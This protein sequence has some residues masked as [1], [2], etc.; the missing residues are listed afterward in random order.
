MSPVLKNLGIRFDR[1]ARAELRD[2]FSKDRAPC[3]GGTLR[4]RWNNFRYGWWHHNGP[5][6]PKWDVDVFGYDPESGAPEDKEDEYEYLFSLYQ[7]GWKASHSVVK[8]LQHTDRPLT[9][10]RT[11]SWA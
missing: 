5:R 4:G 3:E 7:L 1:E 10:I 9:V 2:I 11:F 6:I 8:S